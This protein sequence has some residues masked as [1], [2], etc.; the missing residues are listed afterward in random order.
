MPKT[1]FRKIATRRIGREFYHH[2]QID[3]SLLEFIGEIGLLLWRAILNPLRIRFKALLTTIKEVGFDA[4]PIIGLLSFLTG[5][6]L[7]YQGAV[8]LQRFG[9]NIFIVDLVSL[10]LLRELSPLLTAIIVAGRSGSAFTAQIG[11]MKVTEEIDALRTMGIA[12][13]EQLVIPKLLALIIA[14]PLLTIFADILGI[15]GG[16]LMAYIELGVGASAFVDRLSEAVSLS[17]FLTG[18]AKA[19]VFAAVIAIVGCFQG[20]QVTGSA[21]SV[22]R[23]TTVSVVQS[24]FMVIVIDAIFSVIYSLLR[25]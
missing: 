11:T 24:I 21:E 22:G 19:P 1:N 16:M 23:Q 9:A 5:I 13:L 15:L 17:S 6:V 4:L 10:S 2:L 8:Q 20:F 14:L 18:L 7:A 12:P 3:T 25:I